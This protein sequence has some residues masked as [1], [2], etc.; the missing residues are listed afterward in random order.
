M[1]TASRYAITMT[2]NAEAAAAATQAS[3]V[4]SLN[5]KTNQVITMTAVTK[6]S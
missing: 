3:D 6:V 5:G 1:T 2:V 4:V